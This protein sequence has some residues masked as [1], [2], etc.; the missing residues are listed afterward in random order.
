MRKPARLPLEALEP[1]LLSRPLRHCGRGA[2]VRRLLEDRPSPPAP[3]PQSRESGE[4]FDWPAVFGNDHPVE[5]EVGFGKGL[6]LVTAGPGASGDELP[7]H[8]SAA[9]ASTLCRDPARETQANQ[10]PR[11]LRRRPPVLPRTHRGGVRAGGSCLFPGPVVEEAAPQ[12]ASLDAGIRRRLRPRSA[13]RRPA[14]RRH[15]RARVFRHMS[16]NCSTPSRPAASCGPRSRPARRG[17]TRS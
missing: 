14:A 2:G 5:I 13:T 7:R 10:R 1:Y 11:R 12:A 16:A 17:R 6:F 8:R 3:L 15:R 4:Q 9:S